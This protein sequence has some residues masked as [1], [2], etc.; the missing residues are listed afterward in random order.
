MRKH[1]E[2]AEMNIILFDNENIIVASAEEVFVP[3][4]SKASD[5]T[6]IL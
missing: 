1:Y 3:S 2:T 6:E 4:Y 5:E